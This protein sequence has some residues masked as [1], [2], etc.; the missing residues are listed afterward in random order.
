MENILIKNGRL[1]NEGKTFEAD[2]L[3][4]N[5]R[6]DKIATSIASDDSYKIIDASGKYVLP[7]VIDD[8]V[9]FREPGLTQKANI[10]TEARAAVA[11]G[12]TSFMEMPNTVPNAL[13]QELL[14]DKYDI[15]EKTS[16]ANY[17][18][19]MGASNDN[20]EEVMKTDL[21]AICGLKIFMG[22]ST[23]NMLVDN[24]NT[25][26]KVFSSF[27][28]LIATHCEDEAT[29]RNNFE[30]FKTE[31]E[32]KE[33]PYDIHALIRNEEGCY[34]SSSMAVSLA[35]KNG[36]RLH[37]LHISSSEEISLF[38]NSLPLAE[39]KITAEVCV[40]HLWFDA[41]DY[42]EKGT[43]IKCNPAIKHGHKD[44]LF[45]ALLDDR[46]D[47]IATDHAPHQWE[48]KQKSYW[49]APSGLPLVQHALQAMLDFRAQGKITIERIVEKMCHAPAICFEIEER[50]YLRE[51]YW[52]DIAIVDANKPSLVTKEGLFYKC[53][54]SPFEGHTFG[55]SVSHTIVSG[56]LAYENGV[57]NEEKKGKRLSFER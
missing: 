4:K 14:Q 54:W 19:Y 34:K 31:Y 44:K 20:Y 30:K 13:T 6:I 45:Q 27:P 33:I 7:G 12:T 36:T 21:K 51:G 1:V 17:S 15:A 5:G 49:E 10:Y 41:E 23:G 29:V 35:K 38:D 26:S 16:L 46:F 56:H 37:I 2:V 24:E 40:H 47:V 39:K 48:E 18:F 25:L 55:S 8:Q 57:F 52:A 22:S 53:G 28:S 43:K 32:N 3:I 42:K 11:G 9:H 50:G